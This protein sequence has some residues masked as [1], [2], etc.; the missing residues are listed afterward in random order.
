MEEKLEVNVSPLAVQLQK[1]DVTGAKAQ[2]DINAVHTGALES[3]N[4]KLKEELTDMQKTVE[5]L[6]R[7]VSEYSK[8]Q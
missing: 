5:T 4:S 1:R 3:E 7:V 2:Q 8:K 6:K